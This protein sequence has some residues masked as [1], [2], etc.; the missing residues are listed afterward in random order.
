MQEKPRRVANAI[1]S[2]TRK[3]VKNCDKEAYDLGKEICW[4]RLGPK[5]LAK[6]G[7]GW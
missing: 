4:T 5:C 6:C 7:E 2:G 3:W 1:K